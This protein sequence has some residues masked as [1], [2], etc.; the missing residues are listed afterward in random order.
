MET[1]RSKWTDERLDDF[2]AEFH[3]FRVETRN[4]FATLRAEMNDRFDALNARLDAR[5]DS[6]NRTMLG[7][8]GSIV[9]GFLV[10]NL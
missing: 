2:H 6:L 8:F 4:E 1:V 10:T 7:I 3:E 5:F 9:V